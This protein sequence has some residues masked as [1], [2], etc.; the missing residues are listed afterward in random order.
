[1]FDA[2]TAC[3]QQ[4]H[5]TAA[6]GDNRAMKGRRAPGIRKIDLCARVQQGGNPLDSAQ[7]RGAVERAIPRGIESVEP[8]S[9]CDE[10]GECSG[11]AGC[12]RLLQGWRIRTA[13]QHQGK[14][15]RERRRA[16]KPA[17]TTS[18]RR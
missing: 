17:R 4:F 12:D 11:F 15:Q 3:Q 8:A 18:R 16:G 2:R 10:L 1:M 13:V 5:R 7:V 9:R 6:T 14:A